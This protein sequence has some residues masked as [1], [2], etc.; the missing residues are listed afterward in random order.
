[1]LA[2]SEKSKAI[3]KRRT[4]LDV[5]E[6]SNTDFSVIDRNIEN[7]MHNELRHM[8]GKDDRLHGRGSIYLSLGRFINMKKINKKLSRI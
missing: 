7:K 1:M 4:G 8:S 3:I 5:E 2:L 6:L